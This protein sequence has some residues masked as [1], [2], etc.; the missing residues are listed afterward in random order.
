VEAPVWGTFSVHDHLHDEAFLR[1]VLVF[2]RLVIPY[3]DPETPGEWARWERPDPSDLSVTWNPGLLKDILKILGTEAEPGHNGAHV[4]MRSMWNP[5]TW[6]MVQSNAKIAELASGN[7][8]YA[9]AL[10]YAY[11]I[12]EP[13]LIPEVV[14][15]VAAYRSKKDW[16]RDT[17]PARTPDPAPALGADPKRIPVTEALIQIPRPLMLPPADGKPMDKLRAAVELSQDSDFQDARRAYFTWFRDFMEPLRIGNPDKARTHLDSKSINLAQNRLR[18]LWAQEVK[19]AKKVDKARWGSRVEF[20]CMT[21]GTLGG[22]SL[23]VAA[24]LPL[25]GVPVAILTFAGWAAR[26]FTEPQPPRSLSGAS[27]FVDAQRRLDWLQP[28]AG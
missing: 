12:A 17:R 26:R 6:G 19:A 5:A 24:A 25:I 1:E 9:T 14:E 27:M 10:G 13:G 21:L 18:D 28:A 22:I 8:Y 15:A 2:D 11:G 20:G 3:P 16:L 4:A 7:P 23:A